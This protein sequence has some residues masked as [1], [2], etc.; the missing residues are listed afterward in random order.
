V[1]SILEKQGIDPE[2]AKMAADLSGGSVALAL[3]LADADATSE[4]REFIEAALAALGGAD[5]GPAVALSDARARDK[6]VLHDRLSALLAHFAA[7]GRST[8][9]T[10]PAE[11]TRAARRH[12]I[13]ARAIDELERNG[14]PALV[15]EAMWRG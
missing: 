9:G 15:L 4:R 5:L 8:V 13:V 6:Q 1:R 2:T 10:Q 3:E 14:S 7:I 11:A 12:E